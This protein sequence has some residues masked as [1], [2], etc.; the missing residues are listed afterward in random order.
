VLIL[1]DLGRPADAILLLRSLR[2]GRLH[3]RVH[4]SQP[5]ITLGASDEFSTLRAYE[6]GSDHHL[7]SDSAYLIVRAVITVVAWRAL[8]DVVSR[9]FRVGALH[10]DTPQGQPTSTPPRSSS[11]GS[12]TKSS[13]NSPATPAGSSLRPS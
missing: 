9:H 1:G 5:V 4:P 3:S 13:P 8:H 10:I 2:A 6:A 11:A 12:S 7:P